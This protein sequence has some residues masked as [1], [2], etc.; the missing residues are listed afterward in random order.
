MKSVGEAM[1]M[2]RSFAEAL[3]KGIRS[4][5]TGLSGLDEVAAPG[6]GSAEAFQ[7]ALATPRPDRMLMAAQAMRAGV[8]LDAIHDASNSIPGFCA[9]SSA[10]CGAEDEVRSAGLP[11]RAAG[12]RGLKALGFSDRRLA[13]PAGVDEASVREQ[14]ER[15]GV[16][17]VFKRIDTCAAE[18]RPT[19]PT[20]TRPI[21]GGF[22]QP[23]CEARP[24]DRR[25][26]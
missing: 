6:D 9:R 14:R 13:Q 8:S 7:A 24:T 25:R 19:P 3:Q 2:G 4:M 18:F 26:W 20:C 16:R 15:L 11:Q 23:A 5:E 1:A 12:L 10:S 21:E 17:P 22:G